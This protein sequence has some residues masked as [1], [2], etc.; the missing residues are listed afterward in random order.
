MASFV[1]NAYLYEVAKYGDTKSEYYS[2]TYFDVWFCQKGISM[3]GCNSLDLTLGNCQSKFVPEYMTYLGNLGNMKLETTDDSGMAKEGT[4]PQIFE[5]P[6]SGYL[7]SKKDCPKDIPF[8]NDFAYRSFDYTVYDRKLEE[9]FTGN[10]IP[11]NEAEKT[12]WK[13]ARVP[14][15]EAEY[16]FSSGYNPSEYIKYGVNDE[17]L[18]GE[19]ISFNTDNI[20]LS[21]D[22][23]GCIGG[24]LLITHY[25]GK[26]IRDFNK[27]SEDW[28]TYSA[29]CLAC[30][31]M[32]DMPIHET[33]GESVP[34][35]YI[36][37]QKSYKLNNAVINLQ[38]SENGLFRFS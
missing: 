23:H 33:S 15:F 32:P 14:Y 7:F 3:S 31:A 9:T 30:S 20:S 24:A 8:T 26:R 36:E 22:I 11:D 1:F 5:I 13:T 27:Y 34:C 38:W 2:P 25:T 28:P 16:N 10:Y 37:L 17:N 12:L 4:Y 29:E 19:Y 35:M 21:S 6:V 18:I